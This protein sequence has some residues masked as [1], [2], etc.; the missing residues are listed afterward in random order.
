[1]PTGTCPECEADVFVDADADK[2]DMLSCDEC[3]TDLEV[4]GLDPIELDIVEEEGE[5]AS[6]EDE[7]EE[8]F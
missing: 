4:V 7:E 2:G 8:D 3:G 1:V 5:E 6:D